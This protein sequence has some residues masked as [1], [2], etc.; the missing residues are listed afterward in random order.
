MEPLAHA[1]I[2][3][4]AKTKY[5]RVPVIPLVIATAI[6]DILFFSFEALGIEHQA[7]TKVDFLK[8]T[9]YL[10]PALFPWSHGLFMNLVWSLLA[11]IVS[12]IF[13]KDIKTSAIIGLMVFS[14]WFLDALGYSNIPIALEGSPLIG[15]GL[16]NSGI[17]M[18]I[19]IGIEVALIITGIILSIKLVKDRN[20]L[21]S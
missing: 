21:S 11:I 6:P 4:I 15:L 17:G 18:W 14:H 12:R 2:A 16:I 5:P 8:G 7:V 20:A 10:S 3:I 19:G 13:I 1:S 9:T